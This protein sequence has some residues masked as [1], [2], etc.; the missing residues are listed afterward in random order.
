MSCSTS[1][2]RTSSYLV[3]SICSRSLILLYHD[4]NYDLLWILTL[5]LF[6]KL[7]SSHS[8]T[9]Q[10]YKTT[11]FFFFFFMWILIVIHLLLVS[12]NKNWLDLIWLYFKSGTYAYVTVKWETGSCKSEISVYQWSWAPNKT[13]EISH[14]WM[15]E[16]RLRPVELRAENQNQNQCS[17]RRLTTTKLKKITENHTTWTWQT[18]VSATYTHTPDTDSPPFLSLVSPTLVPYNINTNRVVWTTKKK[19]NKKIKKNKKK[20]NKKKKK[21]DMME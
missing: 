3:D 7:P 2:E 8:P 5:F 13:A 15:K 14:L 6:C 18:G 21:T 9:N 20:T 19:I 16:D 11:K 1:A 12:W 4:A 17:H 10:N